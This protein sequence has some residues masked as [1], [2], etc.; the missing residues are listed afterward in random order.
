MISLALAKG[1]ANGVI[2]VAHK[3]LTSPQLKHISFVPPEILYRFANSARL[4]R[5]P[6]TG[7][8]PEWVECLRRRPLFAPPAPSAAGAGGTPTAEQCG[9]RAN[10]VDAW[11]VHGLPPAPAT[12]AAN[13]ADAGSVA[14][15]MDS[16]FLYVCTRGHLIKI[17][18][19]LGTSTRGKV[20]ASRKLGLTTSAGAE[21]AWIGC[22]GGVL[23]WRRTAEAPGVL[24]AV[25]AQTLEDT[26]VV[27]QQ[28]E[29]GEVLIGAVRAVTL[30]FVPCWTYVCVVVVVVGCGCVCVL[31][32]FRS[33]ANPLGVATSDARRANARAHVRCC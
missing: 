15:T 33:P 31:L 21:R 5:Y 25:D 14:C 8:P 10:M 3:L 7:A 4:V 27:V 22:V 29:D 13:N 32:W 2:N 9:V 23:Y 11:H 20:V 19:G 16:E 17:G 1:D 28:A 30:V 26:G 6:F 18:T 24:M 12:T